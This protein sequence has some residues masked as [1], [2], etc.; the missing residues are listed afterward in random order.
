MTTSHLEARRIG[1]DKREDVRPGRISGSS[2][3]TVRAAS[4]VAM[5]PTSFRAARRP[6]SG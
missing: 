5:R 2:S 4:G 3:V 6:I 1:Y